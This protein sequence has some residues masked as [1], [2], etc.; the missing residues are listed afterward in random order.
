VWNGFA[1][2]GYVLVMLVTHFIGVVGIPL[3]VSALFSGGVVMGAS[4]LAGTLMKG[5]GK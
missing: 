5:G 1:Y 2:V 4:N 3:M